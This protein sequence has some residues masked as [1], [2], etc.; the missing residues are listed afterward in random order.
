MHS[1]S[2][3]HDWEEPESLTFEGR[4]NKISVIDE[5]SIFFSKS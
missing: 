1:C 3:P 2:L 5:T 4:N